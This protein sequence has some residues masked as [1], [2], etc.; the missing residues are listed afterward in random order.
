MKKQLAIR[1]TILLVVSCA[2]PEVTASGDSV[3]P[4]AKKIAGREGFVYSPFNKQVVD[5]VGLKSGTL[6]SDPRYD[7]GEK[8]YFYV[9]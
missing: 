5:V 8:K 7:A 3:Y 4:T 6:V 1:T 9:P 2:S